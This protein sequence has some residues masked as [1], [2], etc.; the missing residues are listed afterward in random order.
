MTHDTGELIG[1]IVLILM[2]LSFIGIIA[3]KAYNK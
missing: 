2:I 1:Q 3:F